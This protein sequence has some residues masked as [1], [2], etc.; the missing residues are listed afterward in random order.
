MGIHD[1][2]AMIEQIISDHVRVDRPIGAGTLV[3]IRAILLAGFN[4]RYVGIGSPRIKL[5]WWTFRHT[6]ASMR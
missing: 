5:R 1:F 2:E 6:G 3:R 4:A